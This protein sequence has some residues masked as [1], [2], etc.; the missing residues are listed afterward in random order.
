MDHNENNSES[1]N[2]YE[3]TEIAII[4]MAG[5]FPG[6]RNLDEFW[7][8]LKNGVE[9]I[10]F[11]N[12]EE[13]I[14]SGV[15]PDSAKDPHYV[16]AGGVLEGAELFDAGFFNFYPQE[17]AILDPQQRVFLEIAWEAL[18]N[19]GYNPE[20]YPGWIGMF[21]GM[22][23]NTY[24]LFNLLA[25]QGVLD[26]IHPYQLTISSD[27]DFLPTRVSYK[28]NL[29]GPS[30]NV[31]TACS[32]SLVATHLACQSLLNYQCDIAMAG[33]VSIRLPQ[34][35]GYLYQ[36]G[37]IA[38]PDGH[39]RAFDVRA[40]GTVG[41]NGAGI[42]VIKRLEDALSDGDNVLAIIKGSAINNDGSLKVGYTAPSVEGQSEVIATAQA[43]ANVDP[44]TIS[45]IETHGTGT[46][47]GDPIE[48]TALNKVFETST[49]RKGYCA[50]GS[51]KTN[52]G[53]LDAAAGITSLIKTVLAMNHRQIP[54]SINFDAPNPRIDFKNSPFFVNT[55]L[56]DWT[57]EN[58]PLRAGVSAF[59][60]GGTNAHVVVE[61]APPEQA[62]DYSRD[63][64]LIQISA[65]SS[66]AL[67]A[68]TDNFALYLNNHPE[69]NIADVAY[70][71]QVGRKSFDYRKYIICQSLQE[72]IQALESDDPGMVFSDSLDQGGVQHSPPVVF[73]FTGQGAQ[74]V[75]M[76][77]ELYQKEAIFR[78]QV[79]LCAEILL[80]HLDVDIRDLIYPDGGLGDFE[81]SRTTFAAT[82]ALTQT[83]I[84]Q[85]ALFVIEY[86]LAVLLMEWGI[87]PKAMVGHS[88]G[89]F[90]AACIAGVF[91]LEDALA[92]VAARGRMMQSLPSGSMISIP[93]GENEVQT[94]LDKYKDE[95]P[96]LSLASV[97]APSLCVVSGPHKEIDILNK[98]LANDGVEFRKLHTSH[99]FHSPMMDPILDDFTELVASMEMTEP[100]VPF[101]SNVS[102]RW[103]SPEEATDPSYWA[104][105][106]RN[107]VR[108]SDGIQELLTDPAWI[109]IE[110]GPG[111]TLTTL[112]K[113]VI[114]SDP[115][116][117]QRAVIST[118]RH[119]R[120][121]ESDVA[122]LLDALGRMWL[123]GVEIDWS[124]YYAG[125]YRKR[126]SLPSYPFERQRY[127][128]DA[129]LPFGQYLTSQ[130]PEMADGMEKIKDIEKWFYSPSW[131]RSD[132]RPLHSQLK[133]KYRW[134]VFGNGIDESSLDRFVSSQLLENEQDLFIVEKSQ[135]G[136]AHNG[137]HYA[138]NPQN[139][140][141]YDS[142]VEDLQSKDQLPDYIL[143]LWNVDN[144]AGDSFAETQSSGFYSLLYL[145]QALARQ[146]V[147][148]PIQ[149]AVLTENTQDVLGMEN[150]NPDQSTLVGLCKVVS[151]EYQNLTCRSIDIH[152]VIGHQEGNKPTLVDRIVQ[153]LVNDPPDR[154]VAYRG[155]H[156][157]VQMYEP[158]PM[159]DS[160]ISSGAP[161]KLREN[162]V[163]IITGGLGRIG[164]RLAE[165]LAKKVD[166]KLL[167]VDQFDF[168]GGKV[169]TEWQDWLD[170]HSDDDPVSSKIRQLH[171]IE[172]SGGE[173]LIIKADVADLEQM[174]A[175]VSQAEERFGSIHGVIH[176]AGIVGESAI[177]S[178][179]EIGVEVCESQ[180]R[181]KIQGTK[182]LAE[183]MRG[184]DIDFYFLQSSL[185]AVLGGLGLSAYTAA[186]LF[187]DTF[188]AQQNRFNNSRWISV[189]WDGWLFDEEQG[190]GRTLLELTMTPEEGVSAFERVMSVEGQDQ[191]II[192]TA[193][194]D[195]RIDRWIKRPEV[196]I[197]GTADDPTQ[198]VT[199]KS[200]SAFPRPKLG[201]AYVAPQDEI[202]ETLAQTWQTVLGIEKIGIHDDFFELGGHS[203]LATQLVTRI[204]DAYQVQLP[205]RRLFDTPT[206]AGL[207]V[208]IREANGADK[209]QRT[210]GS[211][212]ALESDSVSEGELTIGAISREGDLELSYGQQRLW[213]LDQM[214]PDSPLYNN[215][216]AIRIS[217]ELNVE[218]L[219]YSLKN[220]VARHEILRTTFRE[221]NGRPVQAIHSEMTV[222]INE[223]DLTALSL[224]ERDG[225]VMRLA[226]GEA[227]LPF[228]LSQGPLFRITAIQ[229]SDD[230][231]VLFMTMH[232][233]ISDGWSVKVLIGEL[234]A[235]YTYFVTQSEDGDEVIT[236]PEMPIQY[237][238]YAYWQ[239]EWLVGEVIDRQV[240]Y[241][242]TQLADRGDGTGNV[243][244]FPDKP[245][246]PYQTSN[247]ASLWFELPAE[248][249][250][251]L[252]E[253]SQKSGVTLF[254][255]LLGALQ[256]LMYR[257]TGQDDVCVGTPIANRTRM[258]T[259]SL[260]GFILNTLVMRTDLSGDPTF[261]IALERVRD[262]AL[263]AYAH[264]DVPFEMLVEALQPER[265]LSRAPFFQV[266]FDLQEA[267]LPTLELPGL[268]L[269]PLKVDGG[270][271]KFD[272]ALSMEMS[273]SNVSEFQLSGYFNYN[274][275]LFEEDTINRL[276]EHWKV[277]L[278]SIVSDPNLRLSELDILAQE[279]VDKLLVEWNDNRAPKLSTRVIVE[280]IEAQA[281]EVPDA[282]ALT[283][284]VDS[285]NATQVLSYTELDSR[286]NQL[287]NYL[288]S[289][290]IGPDTIVGVSSGRSMEMITA[291]LGIHKAGGAF[292]PLDPAY[293][294]GRL[295][296]MIDDA[297]VGVVLTQERHL[298]RL[299][300]ERSDGEHLVR[301]CLDRDWPMISEQSAS[302]P[303]IDLSA[304]N[305]AY[306]IYTSGSTGLPKGVMIPHGEFANHC[307]VMRDHFEITSSDRVMQFASLN[308]DAGLEQVFT[309]LIAG[310]RLF[311]RGDELWSSSEFD[312]IVN[313]L[314]L[315]VVNVPPAY[316]HQWA[317]FTADN[318]IQKL[319]NQT[320][321]LLSLR[322]VIIGGDVMLPE[323]LYLW[324][325]STYGQVRLLNAYGPT[326]TT[327]TATTQQVDAE[328]MPDGDRNYYRVPIGRPMPNRTAYILDPYGNPVPVGVPGELFFGGSGVAR[329][330]L[331]RYELTAGQ[332]LPDPFTNKLPGWD[333]AS[334]EGARFYKTGDRVRFLAD[335]S[336]EF[337]GRVDSQV[338]V[339]GFR[340]ELGEI[341]AVLGMHPAVSETAVIDIDS[342]EVDADGAGSK[343]EKRLV[344]YVVPHSQD[345]Q[346]SVSGLFEYLN[347]NLPAYMVPAAIT[348]LDHLPLTPS[349]KVDR[350]AL[351][352][353]ETLRPELESVYVAPR[354]P[355]EKELAKL[356]CEVLG[357]EWEDEDSPIGV[358]DNFFEL[359]GHSLLAT[360]IISRIREAYQ[361]EV[362]VRRVF[363]EPTIAG[364]GEIITEN[365]VEQEEA[366]ELNELLAELESLSEEDVR[367]L[368]DE[369]TP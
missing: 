136:S 221:A 200:T 171:S 71:L 60:I 216:T 129:D 295:D 31:Q 67:E 98:C 352:E 1:Q 33:G 143:H 46:V 290:G 336:I 120:S 238:D 192:S 153:E 208:I 118:L 34:K 97:N 53:H 38:S 145:T 11:F 36:E 68:G 37:G 127:W 72:A 84:T 166:A 337:L 267:P 140:Q 24:L 296:Y 48:I 117:G 264:Q 248:L 59:G 30:V 214:D 139:S 212:P 170:D 32:T 257:Y 205:L 90:V 298:E 150:L 262:T 99:A 256:T 323:S 126:I 122:F 8:N 196:T 56:R 232:H 223:V 130:K 111:R 194:L 334:V 128:I 229:L 273:T 89:E 19:A 70:T 313:D 186:N 28:L 245:R 14:N 342:S 237:V 82:D 165:Y 78:D 362:P 148:K 202:E 137:N 107:A 209:I 52:V 94:Y 119:P 249:A 365:L 235:Y 231:Q 190:A 189:N 282:I 75:N 312:K 9:S 44:D 15:D 178:I 355:V 187:M 314:A 5:R 193:N 57:S 294:K 27:K 66:S 55:Q 322:L 215:F 169:S 211:E 163:Y 86:S 22:G 61:E 269:S 102:G 23:M 305:L 218:G 92:L 340:I 154:F 332:F 172:D 230:Q 176:A 338:K 278:S 12:E 138:I 83:S 151:Q 41:G 80:S 162:G 318:N 73:M 242:K 363:E 308:F 243:E 270:T 198:E 250:R 268:E 275:T 361:I 40:A 64:H 368:L 96:N 77:Q 220:I 265:D 222:P 283:Q 255:T 320:E 109:F 106:L 21:A 309:A 195:A 367:N 18:E 317:Q 201:T 149:I 303:Q 42:V 16:K 307:G 113:A 134:L 199:Q 175:A 161:L 135:D 25:N 144:H 261:E 247:G 353:P 343:V 157:W 88:I 326:E 286:A 285:T 252:D 17:A 74:Y 10:S 315:T 76:A 191:V 81:V 284:V 331:N 93:I 6:A 345:E 281:I 179:Q 246:P 174:N 369:E 160:E 239:K 164:L 319:S 49:E 39:C 116:Y 158:L 297:D 287:A 366:D 197:D 291:L 206:V 63:R 204:R 302:K 321:K 45:Y 177:S 156:R 123:N 240:D 251:G 146:G 132:L 101:I 2:A 20:T 69:A 108:F 299:P 219:K 79:D 333:D 311:L 364:L 293:P 266:I 114:S 359:G 173:I 47:L 91:S 4:G 152:P 327:I 181:P 280:K 26:T 346:L 105:H 188:A 344:A 316:W 133:E 325:K 65:R 260:I 87:F 124:E 259:E 351:P 328:I 131:K 253:L 115:S 35:Q 276:I 350:R 271:A 203:L 224:D 121:V 180:F 329:G 244:L 233:I 234:A 254:M 168:P 226:L 301:I 227:K 228:D 29:R 43:L 213:F 62:V 289:I 272:L 167:L 58:G 103:I 348:L 110:L 263:G 236:L 306:V 274:T 277:L 358:N 330:Y 125:E 241:W 341:E 7:L 141:E 147:T 356:W 300:E 225:E 182:V 13:V 155:N 112:T 292:L 258:E 354:D 185:S 210:D 104:N 357:I 159:N 360:Q 217:G 310:A 279:E 288:Q 54:P 3:G 335:G 304:D 349:G 95:C 85:P 142:L 183:V 50:I 184:K 207:A 347:E 324:Q 100:E 51:V 339:R